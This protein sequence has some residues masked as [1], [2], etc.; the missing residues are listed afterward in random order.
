MSLSWWRTPEVVA[1]VRSIGREDAV[2]KGLLV[3]DR[4]Q[5]EVVGDPI[6]VLTDV[7]LLNLAPLGLRDLGGC[8]TSSEEVFGDSVAEFVRI[9]KRSLKATSF[10]RCFHGLTTAATFTVLPP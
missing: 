3:L 10:S 1:D 6:H 8:R 2:V 7:G 9:W 4:L 5:R